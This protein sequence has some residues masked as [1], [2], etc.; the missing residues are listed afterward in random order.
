MKKTNLT[1]VAIIAIT[2]LF[3]AC[4]NTSS[5]QK[6]T[7]DDAGEKTELKIGEKIW[8]LKNLDVTKFKN[9]DPIKEA[10]T[11]DEWKSACENNEPAWCCY[12]NNPENLKKYGVLYNW[13]AVTDPRGLCPEGWSVPSE[14]DW[15]DLVNSLGGSNIAGEAMKCKNEWNIDTSADN[16]SGFSALPS[17]LRDANGDF[18]GLNQTAIWWTSTEWI[19]N[20]VCTYV[21]EAGQNFCID[22]PA[23]KDVA[24]SVRCVKD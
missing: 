6:G 5:Q 11:I 14:N 13:F 7:N 10:K 23:N 21:L 8:K 18:L 20:K 22:Y 19:G 16:T 17:G 12:E 4:G 1:I 15:K 9:G 24:H 2:F 3:S